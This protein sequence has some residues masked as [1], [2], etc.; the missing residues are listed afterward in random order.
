[1]ATNYSRGAKFEYV[2]RDY[3]LSIG[4]V[5]VRAAGSKGAGDLVCGREGKTY[6]VQCKRRGKP[7]EKELDALDAD[8]A[9]A[10]WI[11]LV[12]IKKKR[13]FVLYRLNRDLELEPFDRLF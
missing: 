6:Y 7:P 10:G 12:V 8:A 9:R 3:F 5:V 1:M 4:F 11:P 13:G 2:V